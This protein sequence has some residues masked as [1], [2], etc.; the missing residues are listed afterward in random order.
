[1]KLVFTSYIS[2]PEYNDPPVWLK[3]IKA[4]TGILES[5]SLQHTVTSIE[6][7]SYEGLFEQNGVQYYFTRL[8]KKVVYFPWHIHRYIKQLR[9]DVVFV[10]GF[11]FPWQIIQLRWKLGKQVKIVVINHAEKPS[12][13]R[14]KFLQQL[15]DKYVDKYFFTSAEMGAE[16]VQQEI[17]SNESKIEEV[18]EASSFFYIMDKEIARKKTEVTGDPFFLWVGRLDANKDPLT[19]IRAFGEFVKYQPTA[20]LYMIYHTDELKEEITSLC[21]KETNL[22]KAVKL[23][24]KVLHDEMQYWYSS[25]DFIISGSHYEGSGVA[26]CEAMSC[27]CIPVLT[28]IQSFRKMTG[29][30]K[31]GLLYEPGNDKELLAALLQTRSMDWEKEREKVLRQFNEELSFTAIAEKINQVIGSLGKEK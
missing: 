15:A 21:E 29:P 11:V 27:G 8:N 6:R 25:A 9:P 28:N 13:G 31:C 18:M 17:I 14:R 10:N 20:K 7:I 26:V 4:W 23:V 1:M 5:L 2:S 30:G 3:R 22:Q 19:V 24:G 16:W 12:G